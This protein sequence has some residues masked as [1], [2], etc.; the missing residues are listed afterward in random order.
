MTFP[1]LCVALAVHGNLQSD[2]ERQPQGLRATF[3]GEA[4]TWAT[5]PGVP[6]AGCQ[7][8]GLNVSIEGERLPF[9]PTSRVPRDWQ[10]G[11]GAGCSWS[12]A[13]GAHLLPF[14]MRLLAQHIWQVNVDCSMNGCG[15]GLS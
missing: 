4:L 3:P 2:S 13:R 6:T 1:R 5:G 9:G 7:S 15:C 10:C 11:A 14:I 8:R 12:R